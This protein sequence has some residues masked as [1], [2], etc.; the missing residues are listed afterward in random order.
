VLR[1]YARAC[2]QVDVQIAASAADPVR[3]LLDGQLE[4]AIVGQALGDHRLVE[5]PL[6]DDE[7]VAVVEPGHRL[8]AR[9]YVEPEDLAGE[10]LL[11]D[12]ARVD[13]AFL[14]ELLSPAR[15]PLASVQSVGQT[16]AMVEL[17]IAGLGVAIVARWAVEPFVR[18]GTLRALALT[19]DGERRQWRAATLKELAAADYMKTF[20]ET[21]ARLGPIA[22]RKA[23]ATLRQP[24]C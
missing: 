8:A 18:A 12:L 3:L 1:E 4:L 11:L 9:R 14:R 22:A 23:T 10:R 5:R 15:V 6:F 19:K 21:V 13:G 7:M 16:G 2:P 24:A 17:V 20:I